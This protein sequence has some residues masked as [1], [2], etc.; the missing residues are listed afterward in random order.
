M[1]ITR[2]TLALGAVTLAGAPA[3]AWGQTADNFSLGRANAPVRLVEYASMTCPHCAQF[4]DANWAQLKSAYIDTGRV[5]YTL[6]EMATPPAPVSFAMF[7]LARANNAG[8]DE[9]FRRVAILFTR[10]QAILNT[11][12]MA[13]VRDALLAAGAE[14]GLTNEQVMAAIGDETAAQRMQRSITAAMNRG[15]SQTPFFLIN[16][17]AAEAA[18]MT[19]GGLPRVLDAAIAR[20]G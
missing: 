16:D 3:L 5:L 2:R 13:G 12:T 9:Y 20:A 8:A 4:H 10:Q 15:V 1:Q 19:P 7:Q 17:G 14:W 11:G 18:I 6:H